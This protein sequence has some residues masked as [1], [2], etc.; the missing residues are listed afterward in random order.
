MSSITRELIKKDLIAPPHF[1]RDNV[2]F[3]VQMGSVAYGCAGDVS[4]ID[5][6]GWCIPTKHIIFPHLSGKIIGFDKD[7]NR[8][9]QFQKHH[10]KDSDK[11]YDISIYNVIKYFRL[12][13]DN[14]PNM[15]DSLFVPRR[16]ILFST[17]AGELVRENRKLFLHKG[18]WHKFKG[19]AYSQLHKCKSKKREN[20]KRQES[21]DKYGYDV[22]FAYHIIRLIT[23]VQQILEE[24]D[25]NLERN[26]EMLKSVRRGD[27]TLDQIQKWFEI[28]EIQLEQSYIDSKLPHT[29]NEEKIKRLLIDVLEIHY[30]S[31]Q[32]AIP[33]NENIVIRD[34]I[35]I[36]TNQLGRLRGVI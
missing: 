4:D 10:I 36:I 3:E 29:P 11:M 30:G 27:W 20:L 33:K 15:I 22:K 32:G 16:C 5:I 14:N 17:E 18:S 2:Q 13:A 6:Y 21:I 7:M 34:A 19:Y 28:K 24:G 26:K 9:D 1:I 35:D 31:L 12:V 23:E 8:F 25:L